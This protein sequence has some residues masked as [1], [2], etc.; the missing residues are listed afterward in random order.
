MSNPN[1]IF[2]RSNYGQYAPQFMKGGYVAIGW[3][4][5]TN[6]AAVKTR[7]ELY[8]LYKSSYPADSNIVTGQQVGQISRFLHELKLGDYVLTQSVNSDHF[9][10]GLVTGEYYYEY[11][12]KD[13]CPFPHRKKVKWIKEIA[14]NQFSVPF[15]NTIRSSLTIFY[16]SQLQNFFTVI[17]KPELIPAI[18]KQLDSNYHET[19]LNRLMELDAKEFE[20]LITHLLAALGFEGTEHTGRPGDGGVDAT[21]ELN[22][23]GI[24]KVKIFVQAKRH[25]PEKVIKAADV[26]ALR[27][28]I[29]RDGQGAFITTARFDKH[30][31]DIAL[32]PAFPRIG[33]INGNQFVD[34]LAEHWEDIPQEFKEK[35]NLKL[36]LVLA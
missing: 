33:L 20:I 15:Q 14:R 19:V 9:H 27:Q 21:G 13:G 2:V 28:S 4:D 22:L 18:Q 7:D 29:P 35:L 23:A 25:K 24:A 34:L 10:Y 17:G 5:K 11:N 6:L 26:K 8:P 3:L 16:V 12:S 36:G 32:D 30:C 1:I 31:K